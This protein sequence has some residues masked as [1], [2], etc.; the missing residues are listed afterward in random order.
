VCDLGLCAWA[1][2]GDFPFCRQ[3]RADGAAQCARSIFE[4]GERSI[5]GRAQAGHL[6]VARRAGDGD[7]LRQRLRRRLRREHDEPARDGAD[8]RYAT[9]HRARSA[10]LEMSL[11]Q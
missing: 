8:Q 2:G 10:Q 4:L 9:A 3:L 5:S 7:E 1:L 6:I 11:K